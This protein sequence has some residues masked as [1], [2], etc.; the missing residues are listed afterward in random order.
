LESVTKGELDLG[1]LEDE[2]EKKEQEKTTEE[3]KDILEKI[4]QTLGEQVKEVR[5]THRLTNSPACLVKDEHDMSGNLERILKQAGQ[6]VPTSKPIFE[7]NPDHPLVGKLKAEADGE[8]FN[9]LALVL[10]DQAMLAEGGQLE[11]P[12]TFVKRLNE[13]LL[14]MAK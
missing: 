2:A 13:L 1:K 12:G 11:D 5:V 4:K 14:S 10:F 9:D 8:R 6:N 3:F 7:I